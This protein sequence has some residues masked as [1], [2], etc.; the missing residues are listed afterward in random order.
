M[1]QREPK[2]DVVV[3]RLDREIERVI[4]SDPSSEFLTRIRARV[5]EE[6]DPRGWWFGW[7]PFATGLALGLLVLGVATSRVGQPGETQDPGVGAVAP[8][9]TTARPS[10]IAPPRL[11]AEATTV[12]ARAPSDAL[13]PS[14]RPPLEPARGAA[15]AST[16]RTSPRFARVVTSPR[17]VAALRALFA[18]VRDGSVSVPASPESP[19]PILSTEP[20]SPV[21]VSAVTVE[22][23][24]LALLEGVVE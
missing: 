20:P 18:S 1:N 14:I 7:P 19:T 6:P 4:S 11:P 10:R 16:E 5:A 8:V 2:D 12:E 3:E 21:T 17:E 22:P 15:D 23:V 24:S 13:S 9:E